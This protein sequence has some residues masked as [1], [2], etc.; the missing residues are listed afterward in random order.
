MELG[1]GYNGVLLCFWRHT[2][3][4]IVD[5]N[6]GA[7]FESLIVMMEIWMHEALVSTGCVFLKP[8]WSRTL[9]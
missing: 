3:D 1:L 6:I 8:W 5:V 7:F 4:T 2:Y 9:A